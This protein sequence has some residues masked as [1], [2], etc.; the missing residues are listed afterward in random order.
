M[1]LTLR[2]LPVIQTDLKS[3]LILEAS[4]ITH[5]NNMLQ[6]WLKREPNEDLTTAKPSRL[7]EVCSMLVISFSYLIESMDL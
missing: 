4:L 2:M 7:T 5:Y 3:F 6:S 1:K